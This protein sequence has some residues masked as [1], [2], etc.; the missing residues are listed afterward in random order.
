MIRVKA[1]V[2]LD[3]TMIASALKTG[4]LIG[5]EQMRYFISLIAVVATTFILGCEQKGHYPVSGEECA[6]EDPVKSLDVSDCV[7]PAL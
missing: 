4:G 7:T 1:T 3:I 2:P 5:G 6:P